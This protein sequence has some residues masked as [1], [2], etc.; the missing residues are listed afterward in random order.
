ME[1]PAVKYVIG[2]H[3]CMI[4]EI[5]KTHACKLKF[6]EA[7]ALPN[8]DTELEIESYYDDSSDVEAVIRVVRA[9]W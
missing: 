9:A 2:K 5:Q 3:G 8:G 1:G 7:D 6:F 4:G